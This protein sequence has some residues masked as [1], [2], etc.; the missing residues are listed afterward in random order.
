MDAP[1]LHIYILNLKFLHSVFMK[2][3]IMSTKMEYDGW[4]GFG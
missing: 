1:I 2:W 3:K 4:D